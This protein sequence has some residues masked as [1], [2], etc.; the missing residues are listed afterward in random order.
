M[1]R[2]GYLRDELWHDL[3][4]HAGPGPD[5]IVLHINI[6][7][8][9]PNSAQKY[10]DRPRSTLYDPEYWVDSDFQARFCVAHRNLKLQTQS[11]QALLIR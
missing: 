9:Q 5:H 7:I 8:E 3:G 10:S 1:G 11:G 2:F 4:F 6:Q